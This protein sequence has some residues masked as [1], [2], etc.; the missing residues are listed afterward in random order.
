M[1]NENKIWNAVSYICLNSS[2]DKLLILKRAMNDDSE[3][4][5]WCLPG[6]G[7]DMG[8]SF[9]ES[10]FREVLEETSCEVAEYDYFKSLFIGSGLRVVY[11]FGGVVDDSKVKMNFE[12]SEFKWIGFD[13]IEKFDFAWAQQDLVLEFLDAVG[14]NLE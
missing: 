6:G 8:E 5:N 11:F 7:V 9:E 4:G 3:P 12:H 10:L 13:E 1:S 14:D 2:R